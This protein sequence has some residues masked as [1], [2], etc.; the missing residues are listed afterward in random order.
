MDNKTKWINI[1][2]SVAFYAVA[3]T[4]GGLICSIGTEYAAI[5]GI[6]VGVVIFFAGCVYVV[7]RSGKVMLYPVSTIVSHVTVCAVTILG[8]YFDLS[9]RIDTSA[10]N[11]EYGLLELF[12]DIGGT[13]LFALFIIVA[14]ASAVTLFLLSLLTAFISN[15]AFSKYRTDGLDLTERN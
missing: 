5:A 15:K 8:F 12:I 10:T 2:I 7:Y 6:A 1:G 14:I 4:I 3:L 11:E 9:S 13:L